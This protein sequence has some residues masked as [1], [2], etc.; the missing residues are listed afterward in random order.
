MILHITCGATDGTTFR[1]PPR[2]AA[3]DRHF[4]GM[5]RIIRDLIGAMFA[6]RARHPPLDAARVYSRPDSPAGHQLRLP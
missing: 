5:F 2:H 4:N 6:S 3:L 1:R